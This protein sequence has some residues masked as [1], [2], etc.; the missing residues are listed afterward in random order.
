MSRTVP[1]KAFLQA[2]ERIA[3]ASPSY[4]L[5]HDGSDGLCDCIGLI[6]GGIRRAGGAWPGTHGSNYAARQETQ[7]LSPIST[8][9]ELSLGQV[10]YKASAPGGTPYSLP[11]RYAAHPDQNDY[12]HAG[13]VTSV[14]P[15]VI[16]HCTGPGILHDSKLGRWNYC[17]WLRRVSRE[18]D[19]P[20]TATITAPSGN[21]V[22]LR[23]AP[24][25][26]LL[27]RVPVGASAEILSQED[28]WA[29]VTCQGHTGWMMEKF[30]VTTSD[31]QPAS[32]TLTLPH[33]AA[34]TLFAALA[35]Q[36]GRG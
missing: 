15:L 36:L 3:A 28:G 33:S 26:S 16:T 31:D 5:G 1:L 22:N 12:Y 32:I 8:A 30:I 4:R 35:E 24:N 2:I 18:G 9:G 17:G 14:A 6:I 13:V 25:G 34:Q 11:S 23:T 10:V 7:G 27:A 20:M 19:E 21:T 29:K